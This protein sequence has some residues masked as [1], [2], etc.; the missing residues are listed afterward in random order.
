[1]KMET[2]WPREIRIGKRQFKILGQI[3]RKAGLA[4][5][6]LTRCTKKGASNL[7]NELVYMDDIKGNR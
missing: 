7:P 4:N 2:N 3:M 1:M 5:L 6:G